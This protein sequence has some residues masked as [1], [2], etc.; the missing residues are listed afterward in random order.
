MPLGYFR[1]RIWTS[2]SCRLLFIPKIKF[3]ASDLKQ[4]NRYVVTRDKAFTAMLI[5]F[6]TSAREKKL[7]KD[8]NLGSNDKYMK[9]KH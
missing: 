3:H 5:L 2:C 8:P 4:N 6:M 9:E 7:G 1:R